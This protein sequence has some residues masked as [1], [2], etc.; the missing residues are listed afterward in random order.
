MILS[1][2]FGTSALLAMLSL[3][4]VLS[5]GSATPT[6]VR[7]LSEKEMTGIVAFAGNCPDV[8]VG[9]LCDPAEEK[10]SDNSCPGDAFNPLEDCIAD[11]PDN[12]ESQ[13]T[14]REGDEPGDAQIR[15]NTCI[16]ECEY[17]CS[18]VWFDDDVKSCVTVLQSS[19]ELVLE[20]T[21]DLKKMEE[22]SLFSSVDA[23]T[24]Y[25]FK[26]CS[27]SIYCF[28]TDSQWACA[29]SESS[30]IFTGAVNKV[31]TSQIG[32]CPMVNP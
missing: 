27:C 6:E 23:T 17:C 5:T 25:C 4:S 31:I 11:C 20:E 7:P 19:K 15:Y 28:F 1:S 14:P 3:V 9:Y 29:S 24:V 32:I 30:C 10:C 16:A 2:R 8:R 26:K 18:E 13:L 12:C 22:S 21:M